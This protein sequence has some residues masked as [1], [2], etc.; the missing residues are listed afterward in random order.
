[1]HAYTSHYTTTLFFL[2]SIIIAWRYGVGEP[3]YPT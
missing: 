1:M 3:S 2:I